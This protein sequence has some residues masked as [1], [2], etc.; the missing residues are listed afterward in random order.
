MGPNRAR[1]C[2]QPTSDDHVADGRSDKISRG[3][4]EAF[5]FLVF[6]LFS[7]RPLSLL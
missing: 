3:D 6:A 2:D 5:P 7:G 1:A 4:F